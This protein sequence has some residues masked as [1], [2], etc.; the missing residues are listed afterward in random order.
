MRYYNGYIYETMPKHSEIGIKGEQIASDF[1]IKKGYFIVHR[2]WRS[3]KKEIDIIA[4][5]GDLL[6][7]VEIKTRS[8]YDFG[9]P[10]EAVD[11]R[12]QG[13]LKA[14]AA[15]FANEHVEYRDVRFDIISVLLEGEHV[16]EIVHFEE[17]FY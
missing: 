3:G 2:N 8:S 7:I 17:A 15:V 12:K 11:K 16:K 6:V 5:K 10:E 4:Q 9:F 14:A 1:L 13:H